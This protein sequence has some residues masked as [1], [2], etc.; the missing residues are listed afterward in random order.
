MGKI[1]PKVQ[2]WD[3]VKSWST[4]ENQKDLQ[5]YLKNL[6]TENLGTFTGTR[7]EAEDKIVELKKLHLG[8]DWKNENN[9]VK[10]SVKLV[11]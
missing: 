9:P 7:A 10:I 1:I 5:D 8:I 11:K 2:K 4:A 3:I 6:H